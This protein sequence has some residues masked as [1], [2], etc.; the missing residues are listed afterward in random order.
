MV[1]KLE[2]SEISIYRKFGNF[3]VGLAFW[4]IALGVFSIVFLSDPSY[5]FSQESV[6]YN[7]D[8]VENA[9]LTPTQEELAASENVESLQSNQQKISDFDMSGHSVSESNSI[10]QIAEKNESITASETVIDSSP[11]VDS[12][13]TTPQSKS[14]NNSSIFVPAGWY[15]QVG[16]FKSAVNAGV[17]RLKFTTIDFPTE[18]E[19]GDDQLSR[20][21]V[22][23]YKSETD[24]IQTRRILAKKHKIR[25][26]IIRDFTRS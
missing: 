24:A 15:V 10:T 21:L 25:G 9:N 12:G 14:N 1:A 16:A 13:V 18:V 6:A 4:S 22:G 7:V 20:V 3:V 2:K 11:V 26:G 8:A 19:R 5:K 23:P 17:F